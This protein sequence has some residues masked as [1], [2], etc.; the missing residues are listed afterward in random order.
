MRP[1]PGRWEDSPAEWRNGALRWGALFVFVLAVVSA[2]ALRADCRAPVGA[3]SSVVGWVYD[4]DSVRLEDGRK[5]RLIGIDTPELGRDGAPDRPGAEAARAYLQGLLDARDGRVLVRKGRAA[6]DRYGRQLVHLYLPDGRNLARLLLAQGLGLAIAIPP[7]LSALD[8]YFSAEDQARSA[9]LGLWRSDPAVQAAE[10]PADAEGFSLVRGR[11]R[12]VG[13]SRRALWLNLHGGLALRVDRPD[14][15]YFTD[16]EADA[17]LGRALEVRGWIYRRNG[18]QRMQ[19][20]HPAAL[21]WLG[22]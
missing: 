21:R 6:V 10:L 5:L 4:G 9:R 22:D 16:L 17:R 19:L 18:E 20:R 15:Q 1:T 8:C 7:N 14:L 2:G 11:I 13:N 12:R 3:A